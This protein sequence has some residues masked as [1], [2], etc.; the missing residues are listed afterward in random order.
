[1]AATVDIR[2]RRLSLLRSANPP[3]S[4]LPSSLLPFQPTK[5]GGVVRC[6]VAGQSPSTVRPMPTV[7]EHNSQPDNLFLVA[8][9]IR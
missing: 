4:S 3:F 1:M 8:I 9:M 2:R 7:R 6:A 5:D